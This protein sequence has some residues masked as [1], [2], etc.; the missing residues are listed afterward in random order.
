MQT[1]TFGRCLLRLPKDFLILKNKISP[2]SFERK[3]F[4]K[5]VNSIGEIYYRLFFRKMKN[6]A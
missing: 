3:K 2:F 1:Q 5:D 4:I 6:E